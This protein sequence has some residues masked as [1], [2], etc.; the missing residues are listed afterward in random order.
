MIT[1]RKAIPL[2]MRGKDNIALEDNS[3]GNVD[4]STIAE[5]NNHIN[6]MG[7]IKIMSTTMDSTPI[8]EVTGMSVT[9]LIHDQLTTML[10]KDLR[11]VLATKDLSGTTTASQHRETR[12][13]IDIATPI[14]IHHGATKKELSVNSRE[15]EELEEE[16]EGCNGKEAQEGI[17]LL[18]TKRESRRTMLI[19]GRRRKAIRRMNS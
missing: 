10:A 16:G 6:N 5:D 13:T 7:I 14:P 8:G 12:L 1:D 9:R 15:E 4:N 3:Q 17:L 2:G 19:H 11:N 18:K